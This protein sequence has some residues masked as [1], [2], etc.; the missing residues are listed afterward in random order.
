[1]P[2]FMLCNESL[3]GR[4]LLCQAV[5]RVYGMKVQNAEMGKFNSLASSELKVKSK[6]LHLSVNS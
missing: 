3:N 1:M 2:F 6:I 4:K 5:C